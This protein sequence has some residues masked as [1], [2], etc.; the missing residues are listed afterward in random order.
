VMG[1]NKRSDGSIDLLTEYNY[2]YVDSD[3]N[4]SKTV[5]VANDILVINYKK[6][7]TTAYTRIPK[8][9]RDDNSSD[10]ISFKWMKH[11]AELLLFYLDSESNVKKDLSK[12]PN[13]IFRWKRTVLVVASINDKGELQ[14]QAAYAHKDIDMITAFHLCTVVDT[15]MLALFA[16]RGGLF[17]KTKFQFGRLKL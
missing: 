4:S 12:R 6:D 7:G 15:D 16:T 8:W 10:Y 2:S 3:S 14:R 5:Y 9:Q 1:T 11:G 17:N 13:G